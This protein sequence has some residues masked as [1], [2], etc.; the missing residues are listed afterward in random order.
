MA[1][2]HEE[3]ASMAFSLGKTVKLTIGSNNLA[4]YFFE[5]QRMG[6]KLFA[7]VLPHR[8]SIEACHSAGIPDDSIIRGR[9]PF[10]LEINRKQICT[11][12]IGVLVTKDSGMAGGVQEKINAARLEGCSVI[13]VARPPQPSKNAFS[14]VKSL[15]DA[16][17]L[18]IKAESH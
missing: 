14:D 7:R 2:T 6:I 17:S 11:F 5:A 10:S 15:L 4:P 8:A 3:A 18:R 13:V 1:A 16:I 12:K 9:G